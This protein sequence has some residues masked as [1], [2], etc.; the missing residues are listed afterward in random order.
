LHFPK[1]AIGSFDRIGCRGEKLL[2]EED[3]GFFQGR[4]QEF[5]ENF[6]QPFET[7]DSI[8]KISQLFQPGFH[9]ASA[10]EQ[11]V[12]IF[13]DYSQCSEH[14]KTTSNPPQGLLFYDA[15]FSP[16]EQVP[17]FEK[18][19]D[20]FLQT[21]SFSSSIFSDLPG[22]SP[23]GRFGD[24]LTDLPPNARDS[25]ENCLVDLLNDMEN[26]DL[27]RD[28]TKHLQDRIRIQGGTIGGDAQQL[29]PSFFHLSFETLE[30]S[31]DILKNLKRLSPM[32]S[33]VNQRK[34]THHRTED[35]EEDYSWFSNAPNIENN[36]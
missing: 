15:Q 28:R 12:N 33:I 25:L 4:R 22:R 35:H 32:S 26:T 3:Q 16:N 24:F 27:M 21:L 30:E 6:C 7:P 11:S 20:L 17:V 8:P 29:C 36:R 5:F 23:T 2:V 9:A 18:I 19:R 1:P 13:N 31:D 10:I 34:Q 14:W